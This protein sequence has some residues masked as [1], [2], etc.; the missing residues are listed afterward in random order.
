MNIFLYLQIHSE[1]QWHKD[2][3]L[4]IDILAHRQSWTTTKIWCSKCF[5]SKL[6]EDFLADVNANDNDIK[7]WTY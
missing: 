6:E 7:I 5:L 1:T 4:C 3:A 2:D